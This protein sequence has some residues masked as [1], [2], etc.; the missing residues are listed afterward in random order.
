MFQQVGLEI[1]GL[2]GGF[3]KFSISSVK[4]YCL[5]KLVWTQW[6]QYT[7]E[8]KREKKKERIAIDFGESDALRDLP[9]FFQFSHYFYR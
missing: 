7:F 4:S 3:S 6:R 8:M 9:K 5:Y 1:V 2:V